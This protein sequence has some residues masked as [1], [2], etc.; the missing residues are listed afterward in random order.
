M[1][2]DKQGKDVG[3]V[4]LV[5]TPSGVRLRLSIN[6]LPAGERAF[7]IH[8]VGKCEAPFKSAGGH[9]NPSKQKH[10]MLTGEGHGRRHAQSP[11]PAERPA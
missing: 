1:L 10:G 9:F 6:G 8:A 11:R 7:H 4:D 5:Q 3:A 2:K